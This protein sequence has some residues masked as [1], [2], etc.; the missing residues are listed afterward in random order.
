M[1][2]TEEPDRHVIA[3]AASRLVAQVPASLRNDPD[4]KALVEV[5]CESAIDVA[6]LIYRSKHYETQS[7]D[8]EFSQVS[9]PEHGEAGRAEMANTLH[10]PGWVQRPR[11]AG[12][13]HV[14]DL[15]AQAAAVG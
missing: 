3:Q 9:M 13:V 11:R 15:T 14:F 12:G 5:S 6:H 2:T 7:K 1:S 8:Y 10:D 4:L